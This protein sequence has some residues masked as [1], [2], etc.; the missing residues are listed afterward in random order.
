MHIARSYDFDRF[1]DGDR[2]A[3]LRRLH[4]QATILLDRERATLQS[5]GLDS[6]KVAI[7][8]GCGPG[9]IT[10]AMAEMASPGRTVGLD[11]SEE[12]IDA[13]CR[14]VQPEHANLEFHQGNALQTGLPDGIFDFVYSRLLYQHLTDPLAALREARRIVRPGGKVCVL[15]VDDGWLTLEPRCAAFERLVALAGAAQAANG[16]DRRIGSKLSAL[17]TQAG[18]RRVEERIESVSSREM[19]LEAFLNIT[20]RFKAIQLGTPEAG[21]L[22][23]EIESW[24]LGRSGELVVGSLGIFVVAGTA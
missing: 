19:G 3:E 2:E 4:R 14:V 13:A 18:F 23:R 21:G 12:L 16:G 24:T 10:G 7:E 15:D 17:M 22:L 8:I 1:S 11:S 20:T 9:F 6:G 5:M